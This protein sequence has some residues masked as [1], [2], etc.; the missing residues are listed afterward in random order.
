MMSE[1]QPGG[2]ALPGLPLPRTQGPSWVSWASEGQSAPREVSGLVGLFTGQPLLPG[3]H[4][5]RH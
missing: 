1:A 3:H 4:P 2:A 5:R